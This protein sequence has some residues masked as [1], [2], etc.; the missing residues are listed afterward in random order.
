MRMKESKPII[1]NIT[2][3]F[4]ELERSTGHGVYRRKLCLHQPK[5]DGK[6]QMIFKID[7][8]PQDLAYII[9][10]CDKALRSIEEDVKDPRWSAL[11]AMKK[12][13]KPV[14]PGNIR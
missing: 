13:E 6:K 11:E 12:G 4:I 3:G 9:Q 10:I 8:S 1:R 2:A 14:F 5:E 7:A